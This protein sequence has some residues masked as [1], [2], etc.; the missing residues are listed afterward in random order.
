M[1]YRLRSLF[2]VGLFYKMAIPFALLKHKKKNDEIARQYDQVQFRDTSGTLTPYTAAQIRSYQ[3]NNITFKSIH[4]ADITV[5]AQVI[6]NGRVLLMKSVHPSLEGC[7]YFFRKPNEK[8]YSAITCTLSVTVVEAPRA[9]G[10]GTGHHGIGGILRI[11]TSEA[12]YRNF[13]MAYFSDCQMIVKKLRTG[14]ITSDNTEE[15]FKEY[16]SRTGQ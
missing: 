9:S 8:E 11:L 4:S 13:F 5:F 15:M 2:P 10:N 14:F 16:N 3:K 6:T 7:R 1:F 12:S